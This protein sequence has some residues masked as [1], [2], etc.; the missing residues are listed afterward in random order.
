MQN[1][2]ELL[3][4]KISRQDMHVFLAKSSKF[5]SFV[6][7]PLCLFKSVEADFISVRGVNMGPWCMWCFYP[8]TSGYLYWHWG[9]LCGVTY[10][11]YSRKAIKLN[12][13]LTHSLT[14]YSDCKLVMHLEGLFVSSK[15]HL[16]STVLFIR[17]YWILCYIWPC[18]QQVFVIFWDW[19][20]T[21]LVSHIDYWYS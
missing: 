21:T 6:L 8:Y 10:S 11:D 14:H 19:D 3:I 5:V 18:I 20:Y 13:S 17:I 15:S 12:H 2:P 9:N 1:H 7:R 4:C 16:F